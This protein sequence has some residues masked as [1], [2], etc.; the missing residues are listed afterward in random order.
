MQHKSI[1][2]S[3]VRRLLNA[4]QKYFRKLGKKVAECSTKVLQK[5]LIGAFYNTLVL[6]TATICLYI[7]IIHLYKCQIL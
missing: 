2:E 1:L 7:P 6:Q 4:A 3:S 5:A